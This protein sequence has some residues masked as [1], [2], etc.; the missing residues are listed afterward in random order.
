M[1]STKTK[2]VS[3]SNLK[4]VQREVPGRIHSLL[5]LLESEAFRVTGAAQPYSISTLLPLPATTLSLLLPPST[6]SS[7]SSLI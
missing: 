4:Q 7:S 2:I 5:L 6:S 1:S 3:W